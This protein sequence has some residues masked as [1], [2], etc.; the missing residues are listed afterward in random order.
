MVK[1][2]KKTYTIWKL[3]Y[4]E[5]LKG[6]EKGEDELSD[7]ARDLTKEL[8]DV[9]RREILAFTDDVGREVRESIE[10]SYELQYATTKDGR[11]IA[12]WGVQPKHTADWLGRHALIWC[13]GT[14]LIKRYAVSFAKESKAILEEWAWKYGP[15]CNMVGSFNE[16]AIRWLRWVGADFILSADFIQRGG[17]PAVVMQGGE[18]FFPFVIRPKHPRHPKDSKGGK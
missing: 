7:L 9:D 4:P 12:V 11:I 18:D 15:L 2:N 16:D 1:Q 8:R 5:I 6:G 17:L 10:W 14:D 13:L 3:E